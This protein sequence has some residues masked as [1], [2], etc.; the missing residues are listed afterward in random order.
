[1]G[2]KVWRTVLAN[3]NAVNKELSFVEVDETK[4]HIGKSCF[5]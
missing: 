2:M 5:A 1:M 4:K 3:I